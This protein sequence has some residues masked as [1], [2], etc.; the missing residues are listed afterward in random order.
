MYLFLL[1]FL[2]QQDKDSEKEVLGSNFRKKRVKSVK[3]DDLTDSMN[4]KSLVSV[5]SFLI[6]GSL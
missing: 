1:F 2:K 5:A 4:H 6:F 3:R